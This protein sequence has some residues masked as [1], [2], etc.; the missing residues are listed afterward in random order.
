M[1]RNKSK[2]LHRVVIRDGRYIQLPMD[3]LEAAM[4]SVSPRAFKIL[5]AIHAKFNGFN[6]GRI[7][8]S[9]RAIGKAT[10][11]DC[12]ASNARAISELINNGFLWI[13]QDYAKGQR[14]ARGYGLTY[15]TSGDK[16]EVPDSREFRKLAKIKGWKS[17]TG[18]RKSGRKSDTDRKFRV[19]ESDTVATETC[20]VSTA[21]P[22]SESDTHIYNQI[23]DNKSQ[24][25]NGGKDAQKQGKKPRRPISPADDCRME[26][27]DLRQ[28]LRAYLAQPDAI[29]QCEIAKVIGCAGGTLSK[30]KNGRG[31][32]DDYRLPLQMELGRHGN[33]SV[34]VP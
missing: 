16:G 30:F 18:R 28:A 25:D 29:A 11:S 34:T 32:P 21:G 1:A 4:Q 10:G 2:A 26:L 7:N 31:L 15:M 9:M 8:I 12:N 33:L 22:V 6:N 23:Q 14:K 19:S 5:C 27:H 24:S 13:G 3:L 20:G 17:D